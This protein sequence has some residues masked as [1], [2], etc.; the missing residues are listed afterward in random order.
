MRIAIAAEIYSANL[1]DGAI[2]DSLAWACRVGG[3][4]DVAFVDFRGRE[5]YAMLAS[6]EGRGRPSVAEHLHRNLAVVPLYGRGMAL[7]RWMLS[8]RAALRARWRQQM[9]GCDGLIIGGGQLLIDN[10]LRFPLSISALAA[11]GHE[12]SIP[13]AVHACGMG[14]DW[15]LAGAALIRRAV[16][17]PAIVSVTVRDQA[18]L[19]AMKLLVPHAGVSPR[20]ILDPAIC[21]AEA[22][23]IQAR[24]DSDAVGLGITA[25][26]ELSSGGSAPAGAFDVG[27][28]VEFWRGL[29]QQIEA[30][31]LRVVAFTNGSPVDH[32]F[33]A[34]VC[35]SKGGI[36]LLPRSRA[37]RDLV[38]QIAGF[39][40]VVAHRLHA[41]ILSYSL[42]IPAIGLVWD[43]KVAEFGRTIGLPERTIPVAEQDP[44]RVVAALRR[45]ISD[46]VSGPAL[47]KHKESVVQ[48]AADVLAA[49]RAAASPRPREA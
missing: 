16:R 15:S 39:K 8:R 22:Y 30:T 4:A 47:R 26:T 1:G 12:M 48:S 43:R 34:W 2:A 25:P 44:V 31:G 40:A 6:Q 20:V 7:G 13:V 38:L 10:A 17:S 49:L 18:S 32:E 9:V 3:A 36:S 35:G 5:D 24:R 37:P 28:V 41:G 11:L 46:G 33:A 29:A 45:A 21:A 42:G 23:G 14:G 19:E 27:R